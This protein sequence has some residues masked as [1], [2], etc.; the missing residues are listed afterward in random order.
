MGTGI[1]LAASTTP[2][3]RNQVEYRDHLNSLATL[4]SQ[5]QQHMDAPL[6]CRL[7]GSGRR[8]STVQ[9]A[10]GDPVWLAAAPLE[11]SEATRSVL[12]I[13]HLY[14]DDAAQRIQ[15]EQSEAPGFFFTS[16]SAALVAHLSEPRWPLSSVARNFAIRIVRSPNAR[17]KRW[18]SGSTGGSSGL[19]STVRIVAGRDSCWNGGW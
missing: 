19:R 3:P 11:P 12:R 16:P 7:G 10:H 1:A 2:Q 8:H 6:Q 17:S 15:L 18:R 14:S 5:C 13:P 9:A 4:I